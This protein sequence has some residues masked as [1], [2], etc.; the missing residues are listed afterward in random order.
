MKPLPVPWYKNMA[1]FSSQLLDLFDD[2]GGKDNKYHLGRASLIAQLV[3]TLLAMQD[4]PVRFLGLLE[5][6]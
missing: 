2:D 4:T 3:K 6:G 5:K 1:V